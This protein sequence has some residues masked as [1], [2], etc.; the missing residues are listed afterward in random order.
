[1]ARPK[2]TTIDWMRP[3]IYGEKPLWQVADELHEEG[4]T[5]R[6]IAE[7]LSEQIGRP[8][9]GGTV[10]KCVYRGRE[11]AAEAEEEENVF[12]DGGEDEPGP[13][14][15][16]GREA[17]IGNRQSGTATATAGNGQEMIADG[18]VREATI[19]DLINGGEE[20]VGFP[21]QKARE[22][23][24]E[25]GARTGVSVPRNDGREALGNGGEE[26]VFEIRRPGL[27]VRVANDD[28][29]LQ[30]GRLIQARGMIALA[31]QALGPLPRGHEVE[32]LV[33]LYDEDP[34]DEG[35]GPADRFGS[36]GGTE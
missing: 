35:E 15:D 20:R 19:G 23:L 21:T 11:Q 1:M 7:I 5:W 26:C 33:A 2:R 10:Q 31:I 9:L 18:V 14:E 16:N 25:N 30:L 36:F 34:F 27:H 13:E 12:S 29:I 24:A 22:A 6:E 17:A 4:K 32:R 28:E 8:V 3:G